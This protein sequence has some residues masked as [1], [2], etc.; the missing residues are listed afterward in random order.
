MYSMPGT[1]GVFL[2]RSSA[3]W[4]VPAVWMMWKELAAAETLGRRLP[5][6]AGCLTMTV[7]CMAVGR[8][9]YRGVALADHR[10]AMAH[11]TEQW[12]EDS[13]LAAY[14]ARTGSG[15]EDDAS[16]GQREFE[17]TCAGCHGIDRRVVGPPLTEIATLY[18]GDPDGI[19]RW[20]RAPGRRRE[21][22]P[23]MPSFAVLGDARLRRIA[24]YMIEAGSA[25][26]AAVDPAQAP[27]R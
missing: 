21:G 17:G 2:P 24:G 10:E 26:T 27:T 15:R 20:A 13:R 14:E 1:S 8:H 7:L 25:A 3:C 6:I 11:A 16:A 4:A 19:V 22:F 9:V 18:A 12:V 5:A 23:Q